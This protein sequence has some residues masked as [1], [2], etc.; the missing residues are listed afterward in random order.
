MANIDEYNKI[1]DLL[2]KPVDEQ[3]DTN[4]VILLEKQCKQ[5]VIIYRIHP[6]VQGVI[7]Y[8]KFHF[9]GSIQ[10]KKSGFKVVNQYEFIDDT[11]YDLI[12][13]RGYTLKE[14]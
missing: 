4:K 2:S 6:A 1:V 11:L 9:R 14:N 12:I 7:L 10:G 5:E 8:R 3:S 13:N